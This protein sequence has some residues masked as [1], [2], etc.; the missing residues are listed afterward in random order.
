MDTRPEIWQRYKFLV[1][2]CFVLIT[3]YVYS[4]ISQMG[5]CEVDDI[6][7]LLTNP[8]A[9]P[10]S[11]S[12]A[13]FRDVFMRINDIQYSPINTLYYAAIYRINQFDPYYFHFFNYLLHVFNGLL[14]FVVAKRILRIF[15]IP[16]DWLIACLTAFFWCVHPMNVEPVV[17]V[18]GSK[19]LICTCFML[20]SFHFFLVAHQ[21]Q[22]M[23]FYLLSMLFFILSV[24]VKEQGMMSSFMYVF[25][26]LMIWMKDPSQK[27]AALFRPWWFHVLGIV[28]TVSFALFTML[29]INEIESINFKPISAYPTMHW[30]VLCFY[31][32][33][34]YVINIFFPINL[35]YHYPFPISPTEPIP[36][37]YYI[38]P[39]LFT[40]FFIL[41]LI[42][43]WKKKNASF[44]LLCIGIFF[45]QIS[46]ELQVIPMTRPAIMA[47]RYMYFPSFSLLMLVGHVFINNLSQ[48]FKQPVPRR[49]LLIGVAVVFVFFISYSKQLIINWSAFNLVK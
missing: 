49:L 7:M 47:D 19:I 36:L 29:H 14:V 17:W 5:F 9:R 41:F 37:M 21:R 3:A 1:L 32:L 40:L 6:W 31:C 2:G 33:R 20:L 15:E 24:F 30:L 8:Y 25:F 16:N 39:V 34:F 28:G 4:P 48:Y 22:Q 35:H 10:D 27:I 18:S 43:I 38:F 13:Y 12:S 46:L 26:V 11:F 42:N 23:R 44:V 45:I